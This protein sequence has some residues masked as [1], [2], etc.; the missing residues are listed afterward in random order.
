MSELVKIYSDNGAIEKSIF[1][2]IGFI[3]RQSKIAQRYNER[4]SAISENTLNYNSLFNLPIK[5]YSL[6][7]CP[8]CEQLRLI[9]QEQNKNSIYDRVEKK[10]KQRDK[11]KKKKMRVSGAKVKELQKIIKDK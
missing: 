7:A 2:L 8:L 11:K 6:K 4:I 5:T 10:Y 9:K 3:D 1:H